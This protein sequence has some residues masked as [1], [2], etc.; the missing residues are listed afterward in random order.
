MLPQPASRAVLCHTLYSTLNGLRFQNGRKSIISGT[1]WN[2]QLLNLTWH[3]TD[4]LA[5]CSA[6][7]RFSVSNKL[8]GTHLIRAVDTTF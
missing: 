6:A 8:N 2:D 1:I 5:I 4:I 3:E 7:Q